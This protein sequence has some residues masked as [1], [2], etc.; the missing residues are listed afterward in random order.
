MEFV[1]QH[2]MKLVEQ[3]TA[4]IPIEQRVEFKVNPKRMIRETKKET[5]TRNVSSKAQQAMKEELE[6]RKKQ[7]IVESK[8][9]R[10][11]INAYK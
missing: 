4:S 9:R 2:M 5:S 7:R 11:E 3:I 1:N 6:L 8:E 10:E